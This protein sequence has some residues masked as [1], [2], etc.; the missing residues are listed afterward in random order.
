MHGAVGRDRLRPGAAQPEQGRLS[1]HDRGRLAELEVLGAKRA[2]LAEDS[3]DR[4]QV[5]ADID[6][7]AAHLGLLH[8][9]RTIRESISP[10]GRWARTRRPAR[11]STTPVPG[12]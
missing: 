4:A 5:E 7:L 11:P 6:A 9:A 3:P 1:A 8:T 2:G 10:G 12:R